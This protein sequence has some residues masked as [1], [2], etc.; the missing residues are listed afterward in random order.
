[1]ADTD[2]PKTEVVAIPRDRP[3]KPE[4]GTPWRHQ[5]GCTNPNSTD[6]D[7]PCGPEVIKS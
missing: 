6:W 1:M 5:D 3:P 4:R 2:K 7:C